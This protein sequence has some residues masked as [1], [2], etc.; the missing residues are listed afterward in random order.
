MSD[1]AGLA[2]AAAVYKSAVAFRNTLYDRGLL[3]IVD[4]GL[5]AIS[6]GNL[7][8]GGTGK[9]PLVLHLARA[10]L[11]DGVPVGLLSRGYGRRMRTPVVVLPRATIPGPDV[12]GDE[13][14][15]LRMRLPQL[16]LA[17]DARRARGA[18]LLAPHLAGGCFLLDD[19]FQHRGL[20]RALDVVA[21]AAS[22]PFAEGR[23]LPHGRL[24]EPQS[25]I[26]RASHVVLIDSPPPGAAPE[27][28]I[29]LRRELS[30]L[31]PRTP[32]A[33]ARPVLLGFRLLGEAGTPLLAG[34]SLPAPVLAVA[35]IARPERFLA[36]LAAAGVPVAAHAFFRDHH[37]FTAA[38]GTALA[39]A[40]ATAGAAAIVTTE[41]DEPR[42]LAAGESDF[43]AGRPAFVAV[44]ELAFAE[45]E[46]ELLGAVTAALGRRLGR[47]VN[48]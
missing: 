12:I 36:T 30:K 1:G 41:K 32:I 11:A 28:V 21:V 3:P 33:R 13:P 47:E 43:L 8:A 24:R 25:A 7:T 4:P 16:A 19:G 9:T 6:I 5:P 2:L 45:G 42:L 38:D 20:R 26:R 37:V 31:A 23:L 29:A 14:W 17:V 15:L 48:A 10:L 35:G 39:A 18:R 46:A 44:M 27:Q 40:A 34:S 22:E